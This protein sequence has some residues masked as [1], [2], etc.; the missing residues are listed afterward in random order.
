MKIESLYF[1][2]GFETTLMTK[3]V[4]YE[5]GSG[6][7]FADLGVD[8]A[9]EMLAKAKLALAILDTIEQ[10]G[11][12]QQ[13]AAELLETDRSNVSKLKRGSELRKFTFDRLLSWLTKLD[14]DVTLTIKHKSRRRESGRLRVAV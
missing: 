7:V 10:R 14:H 8:D 13:Q 4:D 3:T 12:T 2:R 11:L 5:V 9:E 6:N 1:N